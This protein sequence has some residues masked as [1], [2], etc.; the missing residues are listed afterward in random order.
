MSVEPKRVRINEEIER[1]LEEAANQPLIAEF[2]GNA[3]RVYAEK[4]LPPSPYTIDTI[5]GSL[6]PL[7]G[8]PGSDISNDELETI[9]EVGKKENLGNIVE[10]MMESKLFLTRN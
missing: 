8:R 3:Y 1:L 5:Y 6:P 10:G 4:V 2:E 7:N 9:I